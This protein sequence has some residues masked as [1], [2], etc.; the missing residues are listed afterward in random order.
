MTEGKFDS[1]K[2]HML[3]TEGRIKDLRPA[4]LLSDVAGIKTGMTCIDLGC[5]TGIFSLPMAL[6]VGKE[7]LVYAVDNSSAMLEYMRSKN[8][9]S[10]LKLVHRDAGNTGLD[11]QIADFC[12]LA[13]ILHEVR[14]PDILANEAF[15]LLRPGGRPHKICAGK[16]FS[17]R[18]SGHPAAMVFRSG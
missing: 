5:G 8:P 2:A 16:R 15:R 17:R 18:N 1:K 14:Q 13:F 11:S 3:D 12:L 10:N 9:P 6:A 4:Q 7:G